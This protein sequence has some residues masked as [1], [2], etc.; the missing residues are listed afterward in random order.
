[1]IAKVPKPYG[2]SGMTA[3]LMDIE[4]ET[5]KETSVYFLIDPKG[6]LEAVTEEFLFSVPEDIREFYFLLSQSND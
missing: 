1:M 2:K 6:S 3:L 4:K 5:N